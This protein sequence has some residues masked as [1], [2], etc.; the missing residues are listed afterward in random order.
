MLIL[1]IL[2][3]VLLG[4][5]I[6][7]AGKLRNR[8]LLLSL[9]GLSLAVGAALGL[10]VLFGGETEL[11]VFSFGRNLDIFFH[12]DG[13][14]R[15]FALIVDVIWLLAGF[16]S[17]EYMKHEQEEQR[18]YGF[19][20]MVLGILHGLTFAGNLVTFYLFYELMTLLSVPLILH[21]RS[22]EAIQG[23]LK[24][25]FYSLFG[26]YLVLFGLFFLNRFAST[27]NFLPGGTLDLAAVAGNE[28]LMLVVSFS[29]ILGFGVKAGMFPLHAWLPTAH[30]VAPAPAS[31]VMSGIIVKMGVL[32]M[33]RTV[34]YLVGPEFLRGTWVQTA[35]MSLSLVTVFLGSMMAYRENILKKRLAYSTVSQVSYILFGLSL[36]HPQAMTGALLHVVF[37]AVIKSCLFLGAGAII[38]KTGNTDVRQLR[39]IGKEMPAAIWC[40]T[41]ASAALI[42]IPPASGFISKWYLATGALESGIEWF[43]WLGPVVLLVSA[44]L[45][46]GYLLPITVNGFLPGADYD[47]AAL[48]KK[49]PN[50]TMLLPLLI[51]AALAVILGIFPNPL[52]DGI[53]R[54]AAGVL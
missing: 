3:P 8:N 32:G 44:L 50:R 16:Y 26:A 17:F 54:I 24:Y 25:L 42:G 38:Y 18:F 15:L 5:G 14:G 19:Y 22:K 10:G 27:L 1:S 11:F 33:I 48:Q 7:L 53:A 49:E 35:W 9:T 4:L 6:L 21:N 36:L 2:V 45:T 52:V 29:M 31:A 39:G 28:T 20:V 23:G 47:Y 41:F 34:Y 40:Y 30:P 46:A 37:H 51:L 13:L 43:S 12:V